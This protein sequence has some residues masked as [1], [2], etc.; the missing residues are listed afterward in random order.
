MTTFALGSQSLNVLHPSFTKAQ[1]I[2]AALISTTLLL[3]VLTIA[4]LR[5]H[6]AYAHETV[7]LWHQ[8]RSQCQFRHQCQFQCRF[9]WQFQCQHRLCPSLYLVPEVIWIKTLWEAM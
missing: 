7:L 2:L 6:G 5:E 9:Q 3:G 1:A 4:P 8:R